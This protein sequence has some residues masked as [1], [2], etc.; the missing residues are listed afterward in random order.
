M[1]Y[2]TKEIEHKFVTDVFMHLGVKEEHAKMAADVVVQSDI[3]G[4]T[5]HGLARMPMY[6]RRLLQKTVNPTPNIRQTNDSENLIA[7]DGDNGPGN[8]VGPTAI[9]MCIEAAKKHGIAAVS[10]KYSN[11]YGVGNYYAWRFAE[12]NLIGIT[13]TNSTPSMAPTGGKTPMLG[14]NPITIAV[15]AGKRYP[16][17]LDMATSVVAKGKLLKAVEANSKIPFEW[18]VDKEGRPTDD[19]NEALE[20]SLLAIGGYKGYGLAMIIE[21]LSAVISQ[22]A[23]G[24]DI[25]DKFDADCTDQEKIGHFMLAIDVSKFLDLDTFKKSMD[26]YIETMKNTEKAAGVEEIY[27]PGELEFLRAEKIKETGIPVPE[28]IQ[29][30]MLKIA[31]DVGIGSDIKTIDDL[32][33]RYK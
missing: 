32:F 20:G 11:H 6:V 5:T 8:V 3:T 9:N 19:P 16:I 10:I 7:L 4:V 2:T 33:D 26:Q 1:Y 25:G 18:A 17:C 28:G 12:A 23:Y 24:L 29:A 21:I 14:T 15:P 30:K 31:K 13:M 22:S 27:V